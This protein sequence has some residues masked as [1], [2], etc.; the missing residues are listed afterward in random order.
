MASP[1]Y[2]AMFLVTIVSLTGALVVPWSP[3]VSGFLFGS[4]G[5]AHLVVPLWVAVVASL[6]STIASA[7]YRGAGRVVYSQI[8]AVVCFPLSL[9]VAMFLLESVS[10]AIVAAGLF[11]LVFSSVDHLLARA[12]DRTAF[13]SIQHVRSSLS[14]GMARVPGDVALQ[15][16][17]AAPVLLA[18][19]AVSLQAGGRVSIAATLIGVCASIAFPLSSILLSQT[20]AMAHAG[21]LPELRRLISCL[22]WSVLFFGAA[23][24]LMLALFADYC[25]F[26]LL[27][28]PDPELAGCLRAACI[29]IPFY[30]LY[31]VMR[32][33]IDA[34]DARARNS[35]NC[36]LAC[37]LALGSA[38]LGRAMAL[39]VTFLAGSMSIGLIALGVLSWRRAVLCVAARE[40]GF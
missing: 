18:N 14:F 19:A 2:L 4:E 26:L 5:H 33:P 7:F 27:A 3:V 11:C 24:A 36:I 23:I 9:L 37:V 1:Y 29:G 8:F 16:I 35:L 39:P 28:V 21:R 30:M 6:Y 20:A 31:L 38:L 34:L 22:G 13:L 25:V 17:F 10:E 40:G 32:S 12:R 15:W